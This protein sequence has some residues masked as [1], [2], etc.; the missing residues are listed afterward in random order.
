MYGNSW[1]LIR[2]A[3]IEIRID[4]SWVVIALLITYSMYIR[5]N[6]IFPRLTTGQAVA[7]VMGVRRAQHEEDPPAGRR[8]CGGG[9]G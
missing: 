3:G 7:R 8:R 9:H 5:F 4:R 2:I 6:L 1:R